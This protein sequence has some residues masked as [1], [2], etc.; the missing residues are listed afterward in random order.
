MVMK[1]WFLFVVL[2]LGWSACQSTN[3]TPFGVDP[4]VNGYIDEAPMIQKLFC[5]S[6]NCENPYNQEVYTYNPVGQRIRMEQFSRNAAA[7]LETVAYTEYRYSPTGQLSGKVRYTK[8][9]TIPGWVAYEESDYSYT[10][11]VL[12][13]ERTYFHQHN[14]DQRVLTGQTDYRF[15]NGNQLEHTWYDA[16][17]T[18]IRRVVN[19]YK[20][21]ILSGETWY[22]PTDKV[23]RRFE[24]QFGD[25]RR[26]ISEYLPSSTELIS[27]VEK[28]YDAQGRIA[29]EETTV[30]NPL[31]CTM[32][33]G[34]IRYVY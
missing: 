25:N 21:N 13:Q 2:A 17:H 33:A 19:T 24:H 18:L 1:N 11:G 32:P 23:L 12:T 27:R 15:T 22:G 10:E 9:G 3:P 26:Q 29:S 4:P 20:N 5:H 30:S 14:P 34:M 8:H 7:Q 6:P 16:Q 31:L 28:T